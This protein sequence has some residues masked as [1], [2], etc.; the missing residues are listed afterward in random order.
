MEAE[1]MLVIARRPGESIVIEPPTGE[2]ITEVA[3]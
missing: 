2:Q 3:V 1:T